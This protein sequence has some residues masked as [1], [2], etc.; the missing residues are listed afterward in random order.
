VANPV[1]PHRH[2]RQSALAL[3]A[4]CGV[5]CASDSVD[6]GPSPGTIVDLSI[7]PDSAVIGIGERVRFTAR[8]ITAQGA[9]VEAPVTWAEDHPDVALVSGDGLVTGVAGGE[10]QISATA[11]G[12]TRTR[13]VRVRF[14]IVALSVCGKP[15]V[16]SSTANVALAFCPDSID[17]PPAWEAP[18]IVFGVTAGGDSSTA[19]GPV[20]WQVADSTI[21]TVGPGP[22]PGLWAVTGR[23]SGTTAIQATA[24][25]LT[26][27]VG[28][29]VRPRPGRVTVAIS[30]YRESA[31][32]DGSLRTGLSTPPTQVVIESWAFDDSA[33]ET[34]VGGQFPMA[35]PNSLDLMFAGL[36]WS[37]DGRELLYSSGPDQLSVLMPDRA[38]TFSA[39]DDGVYSPAW[40]PGG[41]IL[42][43]TRTGELR[44]IQPEGSPPSLPS[45]LLGEAAWYVRPGPDGQV[46][47]GCQMENPF[48]PYADS[49]V[50]INDGQGRRLLE[51]CGTN[52]DWSRDATMVASVCGVV[53][54]TS[55][56]PGPTKTLDLPGGP[57]FA[58]RWAPDGRSLAVVS[59]SG[60]LWVVAADGTRAIFRFPVSVPGNAVAVAWQP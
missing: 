46:V 14:P 5:A 8:A 36:E 20:T 25:D 37:P 9:V 31:A 11:G 3:L 59:W 32:R 26:A 44:R 6:P 19:I 34:L 29:A 50:C 22:T 41:T 12:I 60:A 18:L 7:S 33:V 24:G 2:R 52:P 1:R 51:T 13:A 16:Q 55:V 58:A 21:A 23:R 40:E 35:T 56:A 57:A 47:Y 49:S 43:S 45:P 30:P 38:W 54:L 28:V 4:L 39:P 15:L 10:A 27:R 17:V 53:S 42:Y 48:Y